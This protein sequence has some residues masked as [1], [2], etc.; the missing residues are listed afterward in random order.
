MYIT[1]SVRPARFCNVF[2]RQKVWD[3]ILIVSW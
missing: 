2:A 1:Y 3:A